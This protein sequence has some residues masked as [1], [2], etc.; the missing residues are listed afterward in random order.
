MVYRMIVARHD[1]GEGHRARRRRKADAVQRRSMDEGD[2][3][4]RSLTADDIRG[5]LG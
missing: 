2:L 5:L 1:R 3:F 4:A